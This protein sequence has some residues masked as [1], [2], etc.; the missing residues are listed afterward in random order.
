MMTDLK[1]KATRYMVYKAMHGEHTRWY[2][3]P[4]AEGELAPF[5][6]IFLGKNARI[7]ACNKAVEL[8]GKAGRLSLAA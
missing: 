4:L 6:L 8:N 2:A 1:Q 3:R 5:P 7:R